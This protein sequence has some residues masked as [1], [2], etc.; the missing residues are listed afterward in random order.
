MEGNTLMDRIKQAVLQEIR[1]G[2]SPDMVVDVLYKLAGFIADA[3]KQNSNPVV[4]EIT[5]AMHDSSFRP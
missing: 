2:T 1:M 5:E 4:K 3:R